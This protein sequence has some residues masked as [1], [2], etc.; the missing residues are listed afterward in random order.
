MSFRR[1]ALAGL[2][3]DARLRGRDI[4]PHDD[5]GF[6][7][8]VRRAG[9][10]L[11]Y[12]PAVAVDHFPSIHEAARRTYV[13]GQPLGDTKEYFGQCYNLAI[14]LWDELSGAGR[15]AFAVWWLLVGT[16]GQPGLL[17]AVKLTPRE[18]ATIWRKFLLSQHAISIVYAAKLAGRRKRQ[19]APPGARV[20]D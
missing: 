19:A 11:L 6:S 8:R 15:A 20:A 18:G 9:W 5:S 16:R 14:T 17:Q 10:K 7:M 2:Q 4:K 13:S 3:F 1:E 12:D